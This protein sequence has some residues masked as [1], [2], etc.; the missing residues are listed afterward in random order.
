M[1]MNYTQNV[2]ELLG[3]ALTVDTRHSSLISVS[4]W[5]RG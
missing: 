1:S 3:N 2:M 5:E 4:A